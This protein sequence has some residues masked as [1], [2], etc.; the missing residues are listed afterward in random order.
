[1][2]RLKKYVLGHV[3]LVITSSTIAVA[4]AAN[5]SGHRAFYE[6]RMGQAENN[7]VVQTVSGRSTFVLE[8]D[9]DGWR[10]AEDYMIE[11][12]NSDGRTDRILS[13]FE[14]WESDTGDQYSFDIAEKSSWQDEK[15]FGGYAEIDA[16]GGERS[17]ER[18][19][20]KEC[21]SRWSPYH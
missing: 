18:R 19:V 20:G 17:E 15:D 14:S 1:M 9:C 2:S 21:R 10:S 12:G 8:K 3:V 11:F 13:H 5:I 16:N 7:A 6:M 4:H